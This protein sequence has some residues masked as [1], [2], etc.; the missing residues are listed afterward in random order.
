MSEE[1]QASGGFFTGLFFGAA[2]G[3]ASYF[4]L[5]TDEGKKA[6]QKLG[7]EWERAKEEM[8][9]T[10]VIEDV[11]KTLPEAI[12]HTIEKIVEP[13]SSIKT[14]VMPTEKKAEHVVEKVVEKMA[15][16]KKTVKTIKKPESAP[17][18]KK[19]ETKKFK[20]T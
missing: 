3:V 1:K 17:A 2:A 14:I 9:K 18:K 6:R 7:E 5:K 13:K 15:P 4:F 19:A 10:G 16:V 20:G 8:A 12:Q 11:T